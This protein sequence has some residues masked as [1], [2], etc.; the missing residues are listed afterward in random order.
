MERLVEEWHG[1]GGSVI[2]PLTA[3]RRF[4]LRN[5]HSVQTKT[6]ALDKEF[7]DL[8]EEKDVVDGMELDRGCCIALIHWV[9]VSLS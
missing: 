8:A 3:E 7:R 9:L 6:R 2:Y 4:R 5:L 1:C